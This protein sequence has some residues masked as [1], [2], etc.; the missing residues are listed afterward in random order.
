MEPNSFG[1]QASD[2]A[3]DISESSAAEHAR[4]SI[5]EARAGAEELAARGNEALRLGTARARE[6]FVHTTDQAA[7]YVQAQP[8][9]SL[10]MALAAGAG[11]ALLA[12]ALGKHHHHGRN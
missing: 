11:I 2:Y 6:A 7:Q 1:K 5:D 10:L 8:L 9:K 4:R 12:G 3:N